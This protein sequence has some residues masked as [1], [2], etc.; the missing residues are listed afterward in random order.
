MRA[1]Q[2]AVCAAD[3]SL[4][5]PR[6]L[7]PLRVVMDHPVMYRTRQH[8]HVWVAAPLRVPGLRPHM[9]RVNLGRAFAVTQV[10]TRLALACVPLP[11]HRLRLGVVEALGLPL[12]RYRAQPALS[13]ERRPTCQKA[14]ADH[15]SSP[16]RVMLT[17]RSP[18]STWTPGTISPSSIAFRSSTFFG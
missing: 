8:H 16:S 5:P 10:K 1:S 7:R 3:I 12:L 9:M 4:Q 15:W 13:N 17:F 14:R 18:G 2:P 6:S 11:D